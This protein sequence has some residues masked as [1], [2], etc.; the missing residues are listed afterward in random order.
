[1]GHLADG[2]FASNGRLRSRWQVASEPLVVRA[3][4]HLP[5]EGSQRMV[6][7]GLA[8]SPLDFIDAQLANPFFPMLFVL[9]D[10]DGTIRDHE[11]LAF[12]SL[13]RG[14]LHYAE[15]I[16]LHGDASRSADPIGLGTHS[17]RLAANLEAILAEAAEP[18]IANLVVD[19]TG[20]DGTEALFQP[21]F[22]S[23]LSHV[24]RISM[25]PLAANNGAIADDYLAAS[26]H[27]PVQTRRR[28]G[29]LIL[30]ADTVPSIGAL[31][32]S[33]SA[34]SSQDE[35]ILP[36]LIANNDPSQ[37]VKR[38]E[39]PALSTPAL[40]TA[41]EGF[42]VVWPRFVPDGRCAPVGVAAIRCGSRIGPND[43]ELL[44]PV[45]PDATNLVSA[46]QAITWLLFAEVWD[47]VVLGESLQ[48]L[49]LQ[50][51]ADQT[52]VAI[53]GEAPPSSLV[54]AQR[55]FGGRVSSWPD[56]TA[57]LETLG[58]PLTGYLGAHVLLHDP[59]T[60]AVLGGI[61][62]DPGVVSSSC[63]L[64]S[65][66][67]RGKGWQVSIADSGTLVSGNDHDHSAAERSANAQL[68]WRSTYPS[69]RPPRDLWV[70]R[71]AAVPGWLQRAGPLRAQEGIHACTSLVTAS[72]GRSPDDRPAHMA[73]PAAA[74]ARALRVEALFG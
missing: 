16:S 71:S 7:E 48:L 34:A 70:G 36:L 50:D 57:A 52:A 13:C 67:K 66:E 62:D 12:P 60:S 43:A 30:P 15:L 19:L 69:L 14:G 53:V 24:M 42:R 2:W 59:R 51:G 29:A 20:A 73:P 63:V 46:Q 47:E 11:L 3:Y 44:M 18:S 32:A 54:Q 8:A 61:L 25:E 58:T 45:A 27:L 72:Y 38:V 31:V 55:L 68:L 10:P 23:W 26:A 6:A 37:P 5:G 56:L 74:A 49:A 64:I 21:E 4:Q 35:A 41:V 1:R 22:Q 65:T 28:G 40:H 17:D 9:S 33:A 39:M